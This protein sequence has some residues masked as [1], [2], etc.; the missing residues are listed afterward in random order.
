MKYIAD[1][2]SKHLGT[3]NG[4]LEDDPFLEILVSRQKY[5]NSNNA[6]T[7]TSAK[8]GAIP[9]RRSRHNNMSNTFYSGRNLH[10]D[11]EHSYSNE[12]MNKS[13]DYLFPPNE[14]EERKIAINPNNNNDI[15]KNNE[16]NN[17]AIYQL[18]DASTPTGGFAHSNTVEVAHQL[19]F[20]TMP[21]TTGS[22][23][24]SLEE[25]IWI[26]LL[27]SFTSQQPFLTR[28]Y[29]LFSSFH[30]YN[31][32]DNIMKKILDEWEQLDLTLGKTLN[33]HVSRRAS[34]AQGSGLL[35]AFLNFPSSNNGNNL[36]KTL[37]SIKR[38]ISKNS[39]T[40]E[41]NSGHAA[42]ILGAICG[43]LLSSSSDEKQVLEIF[44]YQNCR[45]MM[46]ASVRMNLIG[47]LEGTRLIYIICCQF[48]SLVL[49]EIMKKD[50][51]IQRRDPMESAHQ[52]S[53]LI[54]ILANAHDRL[55]TRLFNS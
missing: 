22:S 42:T 51:N 38:I 46:N 12:I 8:N 10:S 29:H 33:S 27:Q 37:K 32:S 17:I 30:H 52:I 40:S 48:N 53:P 43:L 47:P 5:Y 26:A 7:S 50:E 18:V 21:T 44:V 14:K 9:E 24:A 1:F 45:D 2:L 19:N 11:E 3:L 54:E 25:Y 41:T 4:Q 39:L 49:N 16:S 23:C 15:N 34:C 31:Q 36:Q 6:S 20:I 35:R 55:Y 13:F 28:A